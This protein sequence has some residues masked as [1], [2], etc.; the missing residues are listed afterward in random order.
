M[1]HV[2]RSRP[3]ALTISTFLHDVSAQA[4]LLTR[5]LACRPAFRQIK[6]KLA[7]D[8]LGGAKPWFDLGFGLNFELDTAALDV[9]VTCKICSECCSSLSLACRLACQAESSAV[10]CEC[11]ES[12]AQVTIS[13]QNHSTSLAML[14]PVY[15]S[16]GSPEGQG[17]LLHQ[18]V[19][20]PAA[21][22]GAYYC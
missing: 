9:K 19:L 7:H 17:P 6:S 21:L 2:P 13:E 3:A 20:Q 12:E 8:M 14:M 18:G 15:A 5:C 4:I 10:G 16:A 11:F 1:H 22:H